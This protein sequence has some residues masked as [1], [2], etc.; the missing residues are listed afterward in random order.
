MFVKKEVVAMASEK[1]KH[2]QEKF[3]K[4]V[5]SCKGH[6]GP[7]VFRRCMKKELSKRG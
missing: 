2:Q 7:H 4:A 3:K 6:G 1:Q 5:K